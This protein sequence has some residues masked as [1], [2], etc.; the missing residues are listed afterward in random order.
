MWMVMTTLFVE[1]L[2]LSLSLSTFTNSS[3]RRPVYLGAYDSEEAAARTY[4]L[5]ALKYYG[6]HVF[7]N[8]QIS[9]YEKPLE[10]MQSLS[11][12]EY[13]A[14]LRRHSQ[15][16]SRGVSKYRGVARHHRN[17]RWEARIGR[18]HGNKYIYLGTYGTQEE[19]AEAYDMAAIQYRGA[20]AV[21]NFDVGIYVD[22]LKKKGIR[23]D[24]F[25]SDQPPQPLRNVDSN[26]DRSRSRSPA[27]V[28]QQQPRPPRIEASAAGDGEL[29][30]SC[31]DDMGFAQLPIPNLPDLFDEI[32]GF[33]DDIDLIFHPES[34]KEIV[35]G[36]ALMETSESSSGADKVDGSAAGG[37]GSG[38][39]QEVAV[40]IGVVVVHDNRGLDGVGRF[41]SLLRLSF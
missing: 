9:E 41:L 4:D 7:L 32:D 29:P 17:G 6:P 23:I 21:T 36:S 2:S 31:S 20:N 38:R 35:H 25:G 34:G 24:R 1:L 18:V 5:A 26:D 12:D 39:T 8:F 33:E 22:R 19:A 3:R 27:P 13:L 16:F 10:E 40:I 30:W 11:R 37:G 28:P 14:S 15:G